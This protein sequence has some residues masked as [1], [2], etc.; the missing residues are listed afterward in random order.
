MANTLP[1]T[2]R[3]FGEPC[4]RMASVSG[5]ARQS[6]RIDFSSSLGM[7]GS[8]LARYYAS[9]AYRSMPELPDIAVYIEALEQRLQGATLESVRLKHPFLLRSFE[10]PLSSLNGRKVER[11]RRIGKRI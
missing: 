9:Y 5:K 10:P 8:W 7:R 3:K 2:T 1:P 4:E 6:R 11:F